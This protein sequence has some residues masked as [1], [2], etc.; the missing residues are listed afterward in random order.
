MRLL[1]REHFSVCDNLEHKSLK[2]RCER[3]TADGATCTDGTTNGFLIEDAS[4][5][6]PTTTGH[7]PAVIIK[8]GD[9]QTIKKGINNFAGLSPEG[10]DEHAKLAR[11]THT[12]FCISREGAETE[13]LAA[14][15]YRFLLHF[16]PVFR[17]YFDLILFEVMG[18]GGLSELQEASETFVVPITVAYGWIESWTLRLHTPKL[19]RIALSDLFPPE[20]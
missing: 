17:Q 16:G 6:D 20:A 3:A 11:G 12:L 10:F 4:V 5:W 9:W 7:R 14:E 18:F 19:K 1:L 15:V 8:R 2:D 13:L